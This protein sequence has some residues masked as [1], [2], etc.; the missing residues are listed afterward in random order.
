MSTEE[1]KASVE[2]MKRMFG[3]LVEP[4]VL[5]ID[6]EIE[7]LKIPEGKDFL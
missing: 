4:V 2:D 5:E 7:E 6:K 3:Y 1:K